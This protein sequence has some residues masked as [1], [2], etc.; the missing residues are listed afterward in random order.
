M[1]TITKTMSNNRW[2]PVTSSANGIVASTMGTAP[3]RPAHEMNN[4]SARDIRMANAQAS[5]DNGR[6]TNVSSSPARAAT[7]TSYIEML[8]GVTSSPSITNKPIWAIHA[9]PSEKDL[10]AA[11]CGRSL[12][13]STSAAVYTAADPDA[14]SAAM[15]AYARIA[16][17]STESG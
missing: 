13:P 14:C 1:T 7:T 4:L 8:L 2:E 17:A 3:R 15:P 12:L 9:T 5:T 10:V 6:A 11:R 16:S